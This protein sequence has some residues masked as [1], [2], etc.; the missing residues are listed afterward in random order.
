MTI[1][2]GAAANSDNP[3]A[4]PWRLVD[5]QRVITPGSQNCLVVLCSANLTAF[6]DDSRIAGRA[7]YALLIWVAIC[8]RKQKTANRAAVIHQSLA[9][10]VMR[11][12]GQNCSGPV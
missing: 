10:R 12:T 5:L 8:S 11:V 1:R 3:A 6:G 9:K 2:Q 7:G 4:V